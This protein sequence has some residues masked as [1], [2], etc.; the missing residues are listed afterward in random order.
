MQ[1]QETGVGACE[2][3]FQFLVLLEQVSG[4]LLIGTI[5]LGVCS[6]VAGCHLLDDLRIAVLV[7][8]LHLL[9]RD[10]FC[11]VDSQR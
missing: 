5:H 4:Y 8:N 10:V 6:H 9:H 11:G 1:L 2:L 3:L 7:R